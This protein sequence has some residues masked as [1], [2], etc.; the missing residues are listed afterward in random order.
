MEPGTTDNYIGEFY[1]T[2]K[3]RNRV[4]AGCNSTGKAQEGFVFF[5]KM[6]EI[7]LF[8]GI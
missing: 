5:L 2:R 1:S 3:E 7:T 8:I 6:G 4:I